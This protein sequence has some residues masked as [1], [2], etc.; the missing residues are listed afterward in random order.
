MSRY[1]YY[2]TPY[3]NI[4]NRCGSIREGHASQRERRRKERGKERQKGRR[5]EN[6][7]LNIRQFRV[8]KLSDDQQSNIK[9]LL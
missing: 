4:F 5:R 3:L 6:G 1:E 2:L 9:C 8:Q 7:T